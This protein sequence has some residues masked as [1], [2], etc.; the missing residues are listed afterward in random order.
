MKPIVYAIKCKHSHILKSLN[1]LTRWER[2]GVQIAIIVDVKVCIPISGKMN[3]L[4][5]EKKNLVGSDEI[6]DIINSWGNVHK[7]ISPRLISHRGKHPPKNHLN[8]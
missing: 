7:G 6:G 2:N 5:Q 8:I 4:Q 1:R 3:S